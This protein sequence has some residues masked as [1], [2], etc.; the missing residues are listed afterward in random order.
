[1]YCPL[2]LGESIPYFRLDWR[3]AFNTVCPE[4]SILYR[5]SCPH[6]RHPPWP[7]ACGVQSHLHGKFSSFANCWRCGE[8][9]AEDFQHSGHTVDPT[10]SLRRD[11]SLSH[12]PS[13]E[14]YAG[15]RVLCQLVLRRDVCRLILPHYSGATE[16]ADLLPE[17]SS[18]RVIEELGVELRHRVLTIATD[19]LKDWPN[20]FMALAEQA[21]VSRTH[22]DGVQYLPPFLC[23]GG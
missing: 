22:F 4:H 15:L 12:F 8:R 16:C 9:L 21:G 2:C 20:C 6:C 14:L 5:D 23:R 13:I 17:L 1:M 3:L 11:T 19:M 10:V 18:T 7:A